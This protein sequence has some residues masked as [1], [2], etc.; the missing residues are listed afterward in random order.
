M[1]DVDERLLR[2]T[3]M[4][5]FG[6]VTASLSHEINNVLS[7][8]NELSGLLDD[9]MAAAEQ[10]VP[11]NPQKLK[12]IAEKAEKQVQRGKVLVKRLNSFAHSA[13]EAVAT[14]GLHELL[15]RMIAIAQR[16]ATLKKAE[17]RPELPETDVELTTN[18]FVLQ[19]A[20]FGC[21]KMA[22]EAADEK[23]LITVS[24]EIPESGAVVLVKSADPVPETEEGKAERSVLSLLMGELGGTVE[25]VPGPDAALTFKLVL[26]RVLPGAS[27]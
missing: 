16:L 24:Y 13:D 1:S 19:Q 7:I 5:F 14:V 10:G 9:Y 20:V 25:Y 27:G 4:A 17:L 6:A 11:L 8:I 18:P 23:R 15:D 12:G 22:L 2:E 3:N 21:V 26:P